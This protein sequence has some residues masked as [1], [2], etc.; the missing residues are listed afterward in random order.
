[1]ATRWLVAVAWLYVVVMMAAAEAT[2]PNGSLLGAMLTLL[3]YGLGPVALVYYLM[4]T[5]HR[6]RRARERSAAPDQRDQPAGDPVPTE[7][8]EA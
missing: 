2:A 8:E 4:D 3:L 6:R 5:P 1:M 7:R